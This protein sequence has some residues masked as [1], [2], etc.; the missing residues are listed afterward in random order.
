MIRHVVMWKL[1]EEAEGADAKTNAAKMKEMLE[2]LEGRIDGLLNLKVSTDVFLSAP[3]T[4]VV[5]FSEHESREALDAY[6]VHPLHVACVDFVKKV[7][8]E[9]RVVDCEL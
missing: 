7:V 5:L 1:K 8:S 6:Q 4:D 2:A 9:R 3:E